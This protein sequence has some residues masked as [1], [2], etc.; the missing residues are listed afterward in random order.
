MTFAVAV[1][2]AVGSSTADDPVIVA[3][4]A[5]A[6]VVALRADDVVVPGRYVN[7]G[8]L[9]GDELHLFPDR[10]YIYVEWAD[11]MPRT[12]F[13]KGT[14]SVAGARLTLSSD[15]SVTW[16]P[17]LDRDHVPLRREGVAGEILL[18]GAEHDLHMFGQ[19]PNDDP[20]V[21]LGVVARS[22]TETY[23]RARAKAVKARLLR[24]W[25]P[26]FFDSGKASCCP[27]EP[28]RP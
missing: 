20:S 28:P 14:W 13:D 8:F 11:I 16:K 19:L 22:R 5:S 18:L 4:K 7:N 10:T 21:A 24:S 9:A 1:L 2:L 27:C 12:I 26:S 25:R 23:T 3:L 6:A 17:T 15:A